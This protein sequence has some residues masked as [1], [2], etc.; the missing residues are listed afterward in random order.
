MDR[1]IQDRF[2]SSG[3]RIDQ[4]KL[5]FCSSILFR[6]R[7]E[8]D[9]WQT[10]APRHCNT[11][12]SR[13]CSSCLRLQLPSPNKFVDCSP[14]PA[15]PARQTRCSDSAANVQRPCACAHANCTVPAANTRSS[16]SERWLANGRGQQEQGS[17]YQNTCRYIQIRSNTYCTY[18]IVTCQYDMNMSLMMSASH[19]YRD[20][21]STYMCAY[22]VRM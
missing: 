21:S 9:R 1:E 2:L 14:A 18:V 8:L 15:L 5:L 7:L 4:R 20:V 6:C 13:C 22:L 16:A 12:Q 10:T 17:I 19:T 11:K 3:R